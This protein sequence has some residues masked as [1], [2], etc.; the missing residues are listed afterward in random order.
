MLGVQIAAY[1]DRFEANIVVA[2]LTEVGI[3][4]FVSADDLAG[5]SR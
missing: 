1:S 2:R 3:R 4:A 5:R